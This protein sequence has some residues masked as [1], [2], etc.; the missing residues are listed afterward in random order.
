V[1]PS[2][3]RRSPLA[4]TGISNLNH[5]PAGNLKACVTIDVYGH[6]MARSQEEA[7]KRLADDDMP[8]NAPRVAIAPAFLRKFILYMLPHHGSNDAFEYHQLY[9]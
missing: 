7:T 4:N 1:I 6:A 9:G 5:Q 8:S 3:N 2:A